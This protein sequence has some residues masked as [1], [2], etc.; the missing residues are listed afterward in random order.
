M[1]WEESRARLGYALDVYGRCDVMVDAIADWDDVRA[2]IDEVDRLNTA[3][4]ASEKI[5]VDLALYDGRAKE[6]EQQLAEQAA[7]IETL[8]AAMAGGS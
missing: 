3:L 4:T 7:V 1:T 5:R 2:A 8:T 6:M